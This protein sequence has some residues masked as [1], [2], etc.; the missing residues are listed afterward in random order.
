MSDLNVCIQCKIFP[1]IQS[2]GERKTSIGSIGYTG[3]TGSIAFEFRVLFFERNIE[4]S[5]NVGRG[6]KVLFQ[7]IML[8]TLQ[9][10]VKHITT[11]HYKSK[12]TTNFPL[13]KTVF[14]KGVL[15]RKKPVDYETFVVEIK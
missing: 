7:H 15:S 11:S 12:N 5:P 10:W 8:T 3:S 4:A 13:S 6:Y 2:P 1:R 9:L 14:G